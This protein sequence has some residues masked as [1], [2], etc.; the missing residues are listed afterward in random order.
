MSL[1]VFF[2]RMAYLNA[3]LTSFIGYTLLCS[4]LGWTMRGRHHTPVSI[5]LSVWPLHR[6]FSLLFCEK[7]SGFFYVHRVRLSYTQDRR[8]KVSSERLG[9]DDKAPCQRA[10][11][12]RGIWTRTEPPVWK[13]AVYTLTVYTLTLRPLS[14]DSSSQFISLMEGYSWYIYSTGWH[15]IKFYIRCRFFAMT[16]QLWDEIDKKVHLLDY[17]WWASSV[18]IAG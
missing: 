10:L 14:Q 2:F 12:P 18:R 3:W 5:C 13:F 17:K 16:F 15:L 6:D 9:N 7:W 4:L 8:L 11:L 1:S